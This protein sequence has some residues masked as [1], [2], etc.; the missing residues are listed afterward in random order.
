MRLAKDGAGLGKQ[1]GP[2]RAEP[3]VWLPLPRQP[4]PWAP[5]VGRPPQGGCGRHRSLTNPFAV[6]VQSSAVETGSLVR[7]LQHLPVWCFHALAARARTRV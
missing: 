1:A 3:A 7:N 6:K 2:G 4:G 5:S